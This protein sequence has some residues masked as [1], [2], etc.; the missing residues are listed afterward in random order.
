MANNY[1]KID[2][3]FDVVQENYPWLKELDGVDYSWD[4]N[5]WARNDL[6]NDS[7]PYIIGTTCQIT[8]NPNFD[9]FASKTILVVKGEEYLLKNE[10][11]V[12]E[13]YKL[14]WLV[15][16]NEYNIG[17]TIKL[18]E[19]TTINAK[20]ILVGEVNFKINTDIALILNVY[21][22]YENFQ[23]SLFIDKNDNTQQVVSIQLLR[24]KNYIIKISTLYI[25][26]ITLD[27][28]N[29]INGAKLNG[30]E[31]NFVLTNVSDVITINVVGSYG[32]NTIII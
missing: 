14:S 4:F 8:F 25:A 27:I 20:W 15:N 18:T 21:D 5:I 2:T 16:N 31:L 23:Y 10:G 30:R 11:F 7:Y 12:R 9:S 28:Q 13:G 19:N 29:S 3:T 26:N 22:E 17:E 24:D 32:N 6:T 1:F